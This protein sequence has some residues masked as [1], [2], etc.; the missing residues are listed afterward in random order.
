[1]HGLTVRA[2]AGIELDP[3]NETLYSNRA[4]CVLELGRANEALADARRAISIA[5]DWFKV[6]LGDLN[7]CWVGME[8]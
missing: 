6:G 4:A 3:T 2:H 7:G 8:P 5:P 1:M